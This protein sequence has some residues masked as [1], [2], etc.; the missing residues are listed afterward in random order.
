MI[1]ISEQ[2]RLAEGG[3]IEVYSSGSGRSIDAAAIQIADGVDGVEQVQPTASAQLLVGDTETFTWGLPIDPI[4]RYQ[5]DQGRWFNDADDGAL[6][7]VVGPALANIHDLEVGDDLTVQTRD[8]SLTVEVIG[9]DT[10]MVGDG[11]A[12]FLPLSTLLDATGRSEASFMWLTTTSS[13][14]ADIDAVG[15]EVRRQLESRGYGFG[16]DL[17]YVEREADRATDTMI[18]AVIMSMGLPVVAIGMIGLAGAITTS[19]LDRRREIG[20]LR[21]IGAG[22]RDIRRIF[23]TEAVTIVLAGWLVGIALGYVI[24]RIILLAMNESFDVEFVLQ[25][26]L[27]PIP[28]SLLITLL[29]AVVV[30]AR[31]IGHASRLSPSISLRYE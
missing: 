5:L 9:T 6:V 30:L 16:L 26:P 11:L 25:Y 22:R 3:D 31:P 17:R 8:R 19:A 18:I 14:H 28:L 13:E 21:S 1:E 29:V 23:R 2:S 20:V 4:Y 12:V 27:W 7:A 15:A 10:T 24:G